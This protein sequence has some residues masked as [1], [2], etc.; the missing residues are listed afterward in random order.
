MGP[1]P[2][3]GRQKFRGGATKG[4]YPAMRAG[5]AR[6]AVV[7]WLAFKDGEQALG[8]IVGNCPMT[9]T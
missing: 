3:R 7:Q 8:L 5:L 4:F 1:S 2:C 6:H 9:L